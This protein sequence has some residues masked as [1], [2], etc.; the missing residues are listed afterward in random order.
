MPAESVTEMRT[1][2]EPPK[3][4]LWSLPVEI[5]LSILSH[6]E[7]QGLKCLRQTCKFLCST[8]EPILF[9]IIVVVPHLDSLKAFVSLSEHPTIRKCV[10][11]LIYDNRWGDFTSWVWESPHN[12]SQI[13]DCDRDPISRSEN[14]PV[15]RLLD[16]LSNG[17]LTKAC[18]DVEIAYLSRA[19]SMLPSLSSLSFHESGMS[20]PRN[21]ANIPNFY[22][23]LPEM[24]QFEG[25]RWDCLG[26]QNPP[27]GSWG[28]FSALPAISPPRCQC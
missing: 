9:Q 17:A 8:S 21:F 22:A 10:Q 20:G 4:C 28:V 1:A 15:A 24:G 25:P 12:D 16:Q 23:R 7:P 11:R 13:L 26:Y 18:M 2:V 5:L 3:A 27:Q 14:N 6:V 19:F